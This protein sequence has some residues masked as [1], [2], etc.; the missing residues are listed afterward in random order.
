MLGV[1]DE[2]ALVQMLDERLA[3]AGDPVARGLQ[4][5]V[6]HRRLDALV[7]PEV[8]E[9]TRPSARSRKLPGCG[10]PENSWWRYIEPK[11]KRKRISPSRSRSAAGR[12]L[13]LLEAD[14]VDELADEH[15]LARERGDDVR[16]VDEGVTPV[17]RAIR[18]LVLRL[19]LVVELLVDAR[20]DLLGGARTSRRGARPL[21]AAA[22]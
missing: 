10:S 13:Q 18:A 20:A 2:A 17:E 11:K 1:A 16:H 3:V 5:E 8:Q 12:A 15:P 21:A 9:A 7:Q 22:G 19:E 6:G 14:A 4:L